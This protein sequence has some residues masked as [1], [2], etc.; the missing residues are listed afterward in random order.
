MDWLAAVALAPGR[1]DIAAYESGPALQDG[2]EQEE[3]DTPVQLSKNRRCNA[4]LVQ[5]WCST[6]API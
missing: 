6:Q 1:V 5:S 3:G 2:R 4:F